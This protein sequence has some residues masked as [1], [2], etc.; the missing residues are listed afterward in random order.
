MRIA[1]R[2]L[3]LSLFGFSAATLAAPSSSCVPV[4]SGA[5]I[6]MTPMMPMGAGFFSVRNPCR[7]EVVIRGVASARFGD[8]S[9]HETRIEAGVSRMR[10][11]ERVVLRP[12]DRVDFRPGGRHLMLMRPDARVV[13][14]TTA[15]VDLQL[16]NGRVVPVDFDVRSATP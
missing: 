9:M 14:G 10:P 5:W 7:A 6:R 16:A 11:L 2:L 13:P 1:P 4:V 3:L 8:A 12:G 15:R